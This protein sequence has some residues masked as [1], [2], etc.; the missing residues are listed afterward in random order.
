[1]RYRENKQRA[2]T[3]NINPETGELM[4]SLTDQSQA[5]DSDI[6][7]IV[8]RFLK[9]GHAAAPGKPMY[10]DFTQL[11][12]DLRGFLRT[13]QSLAHY[14]QRLPEALRDLTTEQLL[15]L[16]PQ[17]IA[18]RLQPPTQPENPEAKP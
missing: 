14:Q 18:T 13:A 9:T 5:R 7:V 10:G 1:M 16:T 6:N 3:N 12:E 4:P 15:L 2:I 17:E 8:G 11:P